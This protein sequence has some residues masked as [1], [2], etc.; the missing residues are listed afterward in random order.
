MTTRDAVHPGSLP[1]GVREAWALLSRAA[2]MLGVFTGEADN[3][4]EDNEV[5]AEAGW[6]T[7][8]SLLP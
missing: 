3:P 1:R 4:K 8:R 6:G 5:V 2:Q 7:L